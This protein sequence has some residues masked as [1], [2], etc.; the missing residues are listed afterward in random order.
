MTPDQRL[1]RIFR[2]LA[3]VVEKD[4]TLSKRIEEALDGSAGKSPPSQNRRRRKPALL[5]PFTEYS[6][7]EESLL[8]KLRQLDIEAL[9]DIVA[10]YGMDPSMLV[11]K[12]KSL[13]R[14]VDHI[15]TTVR[16]RAQRGDAFRR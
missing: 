6:Q 16:A 1:R 14:L 13:N 12:W 3:E 4:P 2:V 5:D 9:K 15:M 10:Q 8:A 7:G 11:M